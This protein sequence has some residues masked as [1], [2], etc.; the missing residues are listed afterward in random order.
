MRIFVI[1]FIA[2]MTLPAFA[3]SGNSLFRHSQDAARMRHMRGRP[4]AGSNS[5]QV[6]GV[7][8][9]EKKAGKKSEGVSTRNASWLSVNQPV[10]KGFRVHDLVTIIVNEVSSN[11][12]KAETTT[13][14][15]NTIDA[16]LEEWF[17]LTKD[18]VRTPS[19]AHGSPQFKASLEQ[20]FEGEGDVS[21]ED[22]LTARIQAEVI[23]VMPNGNLTLEAVHTV[24]TDDDTT[25]ITLTGVCR[26][27]D[28]GFDNSIRSSHLARLN[29]KKEH[30]GTVR[31][32]T[33]KGWLSKLFDFLNP[34]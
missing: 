17:V 16:K 15:T 13:E 29:I 20:E 5:S 23:D 21:R 8:K 7:A 25:V 1:F 26:S 2:V 30:S 24:A 33:R 34:I 14:R 10:P 19:K 31:D 27:K 6:K 9:S 3:G 4:P 28:V 11:S 32:A 22:S 12:T 18:S